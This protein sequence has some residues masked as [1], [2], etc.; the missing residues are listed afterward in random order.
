MTKPAASAGPNRATVTKPNESAAAKA[1]AKPTSAKSDAAPKKVV[2]GGGGGGDAKKEDKKIPEE[3]DL[4][5]ETVEEK[6]TELFGAEC[7]A[8]LGASNWKE[9]QSGMETLANTLNRMIPEETP[10]QVIV[11]IVA[12]KPGFKDS[13]FQVLKQRLDLICKLADTG[14]KFSQRSASYCLVDIADKIGDV[15]NSGQAKEALSKIAEQCTLPYVCQQC[16]GPILIEGKNPKNQEQA[17]LWLSQA[18]KEFGYQG[19][20]TKALV[21]YIKTSLQNSNP[22]VRAAAVQLTAVIFMYLGANF[23]FGLLFPFT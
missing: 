23:R 9:R 10:V 11:R 1:P 3:P 19:M 8:S 18:I 5:Q 6:A 21:N 13:H 15:K 7:V 20:D 17:L 2:K 12:K 14:Y 22:S 16:L 4:A